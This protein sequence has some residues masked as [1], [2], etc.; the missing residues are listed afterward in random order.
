MSKGKRQDEKRLNGIRLRFRYRNVKGEVITD[1]G[2]TVMREMKGHRGR[3]L[4]VDLASGRFKDM[5]VGED[6]YR[7][8]LGGSGLGS[9]LLSELTGS[10]TDPLGPDNVLIYMTGPFAGTKVPT[11]GR[12]QILSKSPL[13]GIFGEGDVG[14]SWGSTLKKAGYDGVVVKGAS[15]KPVGIYIDEDKVEIFPAEELWG[16]DSF[17]T[18]GKLKEKYGK[19]TSVSCI[20]P[21]GEKK[22]L[23]SC[24]VH[25]GSNARVVGRC[26]LGA[27]MGSKNLKAVAVKGGMEVA[28]HDAE[29]F[30]ELQKR[31][32]PMLVEGTKGMKAFGTAGGVGGANQV[33][34]LPVKNWSR[35]DW[36]EAAQISGQKMAE[37][38]LKGSYFCTSCPIGCGRDVAITE[39]PYAGVEGAGPEY[40]TLG[41]LGSSCMVGDLEA[42]TYAADLC[43]RWGLDTI[44]VGSAIAMTMELY[45]K[46]I[47]TKEDLGGR[48]LEWGDAGG[49]VEMVKQIAS[50]EGFGRTLG[51]GVKKASEAIGKGAEKYAIQVKGLALPA[52]DPRCYSSM[53]VGYATSNR[54]AC[55]LQGGS[56]F[57]EKA[58]TLPEIGYPEVLDRFRT[59]GKGILNVKSQNI[60]SVMDSLK[61]C[62]FTFYGGLKL[63]HVVEYLEAVTGIK[64]TVEELLETGERIYNLKRLYNV[65][66]GIGASD[67]TLP[68]R[69]TSEPRH[70]GGTRDYVPDLEAMLSEYYEA[71]GWDSNGRPTKST[72]ERLGLGETGV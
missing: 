66:C 56:Y 22:I 51:M 17:A 53:A 9:Y 3:I 38:M 14:G 4:E 41:M 20:G 8:Y 42:V 55:H 47:V 19:E 31:V 35:G 45:E 24:I 58:V 16:L 70:D 28:L 64:M 18:D 48:S 52:H 36:E 26:G 1:R 60:M 25:D 54:G 39:G 5:E 43:N 71:R 49:M 27:V 57:F 50:G 40:E 44:E 68:A 37:T 13:T 33:G 11:S 30:A 72:L 59:E 69:I 62:K 6:I 34:D 21:S 29:K 10:D 23:S 7:K 67:D 61:M 65:E 2:E 63:T 15:A 46:G 12:H 32:L